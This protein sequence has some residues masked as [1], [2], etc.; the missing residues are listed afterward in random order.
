MKLPIPTPANGWARAIAQVLLNISRRIATDGVVALK[1]SVS[2]AT[3]DGRNASDSN[4]GSTQHTAS[5]PRRRRTDAAPVRQ[6]MAK[7]SNSDGPSASQAPR[8]L[9]W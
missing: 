1:A 2:R 8:V 5:M 4:S 3:S 9:L 7:R 6:P